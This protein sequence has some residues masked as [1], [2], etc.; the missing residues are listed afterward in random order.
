MTDD[1]GNLLPEVGKSATTDIQRLQQEIQHL[2]REN[3]Q[4]QVRTQGVQA[5]GT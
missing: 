4:L 3:R 2:Q 1:H 5:L